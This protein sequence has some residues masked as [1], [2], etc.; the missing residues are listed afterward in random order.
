MTSIDQIPAYP[1]VA[2]LNQTHCELLEKNF[3]KMQ[4]VVSEMT[5]A[6]LWSWKRYINTSISQLEGTILVLFYNSRKKENIALQPLTVDDALAGSVIVSALKEGVIDAFARVPEELVSRLKVDGC[7][8]FERE[9]HRDD[10]VYSAD[11][12]I[13][14]PGQKFHSKRNHIKQFGDKAPDAQYHDIEDGLVDK[15]LVFTRQWLAE[16]PKKDLPGL[17]R[18]VETSLFML[19]NLESLGLKGGAIVDGD[20]NLVAYALGEPLNNDTFVVRVEKATTVFPGT[21]QAVNQKFIANA[22]H[23]FKWINREQDLGVPGL[24]RAK[25]SY[26]P[27]RMVKKY[28]MELTEFTTA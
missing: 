19:D 20:N 27:T 16:H 22:A 26:N 5:F 10:Y 15:C 8:Q 4:P 2:P 17:R 6:Y 28:R 9:R 13:H 12:L 3:E 21:Y 1:E 11:D 14:L 7:V 24:R 25:S 23:D 18:E